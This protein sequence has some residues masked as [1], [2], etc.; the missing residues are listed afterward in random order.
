MR[1]KRDA[2]S[3]VDPSC[4]PPPLLELLR[5]EA[6]KLQGMAPEDVLLFLSKVYGPEDS[7]DAIQRLTRDQ[8]SSPDWHKYR[9]GLVT[10]S[11]AHSCMTKAN[12]FLRSKGKVKIDSFINLTVKST[13][14][15]TAA[16]QAGTEKE[17]A[18]RSM[19]KQWKEAQ[20]HQ[21]VV[22]TMGL[23]LHP[24]FSFIA[25]SPDGKATFSCSCCEGKEVLLEIKCPVK[26]ENS[27]SNFELLQP[28]REYVTQL[29]AQ[30]GICGVQQADFFVFHSATSFCCA[31]VDY[32]KSIFESSKETIVDIYK[33][34]AIS[35]LI[36]RVTT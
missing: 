2:F 9:R 12:A 3:P 22:E 19:Y 11:R 21:L 18:A 33:G 6:T 23:V 1:F 13:G 35:E 25:C 27:F 5:K 31:A 30:M 26:L 28:K 16:M 29:Q 34:G 7:R 4:P 10:A 20:G 8:A 32:D 36:S 24:E 14:V 15:R 17:P